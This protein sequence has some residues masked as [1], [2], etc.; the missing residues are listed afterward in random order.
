MTCVAG[1]VSRGRVVIGADSAGL[2]GWHMTLRA[3]S[4]VFES[5]GLLYGFAGSFRLGQILRYRFSPPS[6]DGNDAFG[7]MVARFVPALRAVVAAEISS[8][9]QSESPGDFLVGY[10]GHLFEVGSDFQIG[11]NLDGIAAVGCGR[12]PA[13]GAMTALRRAQVHMT[14]REIVSRALETAERLCGG[15]RGPF[16]V[17]SLEAT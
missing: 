8:K 14:S 4:K 17:L 7:Y 13:L 15:V 10:A 11:E 9:A 16:T 6:F 2:S 12:E 5:K 3:D 1:M